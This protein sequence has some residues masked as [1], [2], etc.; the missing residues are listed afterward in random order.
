MKTRIGL[1]IITSLILNSCLLFDSNPETSQDRAT[2]RGLYLQGEPLPHENSCA[3]LPS[4]ITGWWTGNGS[5]TDTLNAQRVGIPYGEASFAEAYTG[6]GF[7][8]D[9][10]GD[11]IVLSGTENLNPTQEFTIETW[12]FLRQPISY[13]GVVTKGNLSTFEESY[14]LFIYGS[15]GKLS[16]IVNG[17][18]NSIGR[19]ILVGPTVPLN[20][21]VHAVAT[22]SGT[23]MKIYMDG[24]LRIT[25]EHLMG[26]A[27]SLQPIQIGMYEKSSDP[28]S[29]SGFNGLIDEV[30]IYNRALSDQEVFDLYNAGKLGK[31]YPQPI[32]TPPSDSQ[33]TP[34]T[35][36]I[37]S[38][39]TPV[40]PPTDSQTT[41]VTPP[42]DSQTTPVIPPTDSQTTPVT[43]PIDSQATPVIPPTDSQTTPV[44]PPI[45]S[46]ATP[47][48]PPLD[49]LRD[50][51]KI[52]ALVQA[53]LDSN[54]LT[55]CLLLRRGIKKDT[56]WEQREQRRLLIRKMYDTRK[57]VK[58]CID[59]EKPQKILK[60]LL[61]EARRQ[62]PQ[63]K[64]SV[65][66]PAKKR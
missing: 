15:S 58:Q 38:Q 39:T 56:A 10:M 17:Y 47:V 50:C 4:G 37:D 41:P 19:T 20:T 46:Q 52:Q 8:F 31:C 29:T 57:Q 13:A 45:D 18:G 43:P 1:F 25:K 7:N 16:F 40:I 34:V 2:P 44:T 22:F 51:A 66:R 62:Q 53:C 5:Y 30:G 24:Y 60:E 35:P 54:S 11:R 23:T 33:P 36:P 61:K 12:L 26:I 49:T 28:A 27:P 55:P 14:G 64:K 9:G 59:Q 3:V 42:T 65:V 48:L 21:W 32:V 63:E 6:Q